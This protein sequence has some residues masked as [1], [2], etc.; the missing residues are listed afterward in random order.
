MSQGYAS[1]F[2][3]PAYQAKIREQAGI[4]GDVSFV[5]ETVLASPI[6]YVVASSTDPQ[7]VTGAASSMATA[8]SDQVNDAVRAG[9]D[10]SIAAVLESFD[11]L[12]APGAVLSPQAQN[13]MQERIGAITADDTNQLQVIQ[14]DSTVTS[15]TPDQIRAIGLRLVAGAVVGCFVALGLGAATRA[16]RVGVRCDRPDW[17]ASAHDCGGWRRQGSGADS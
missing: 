5:A 7:A 4:T 16:A 14:L 13:Q 1:Y 11:E 6:I 8:L 3:D 15:S 12:G 2:N 10:A 9:H 17:T